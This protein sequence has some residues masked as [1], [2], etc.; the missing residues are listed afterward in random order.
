MPTYECSNC[1]TKYMTK[2]DGNFNCCNLKCNNA[3]LYKVLIPLASQRSQPYQKRTSYAI[4]NSKLQLK[5]TTQKTQHRR[6]RTYDGKTDTL[7]PS[8]QIDYREKHDDDEYENSDDE[9]AT[10]AV[11]ALVDNEELDREA[12]DSEFVPTADRW[13]FDQRLTIGDMKERTQYPN[14]LSQIKKSRLSP[15]T[16]QIE[17]ERAKDCAQIIGQALGVS[18]V[19]AWAIS[20]Q[21]GAPIGRRWSLGE[22]DTAEWCH[23]VGVALGGKTTDDNLVAASY[24]ANT[25]MGVIEK[26][27]QGRTDLEVEIRV[28]GQQSALFGSK[29]S[30]NYDHIAEKI[31]YAISKVG[32]GSAL[33]A[34]TIDALI[35]GFSKADADK[36]AHAVKNALPSFK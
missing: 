17:G 9:R 19:S 34:F 26:A 22:K 11:L 36:V 20:N 3:P 12:Q 35:S 1:S 30:K 21:V 16:A 10:K 13:N 8:K 4:A 14:G 29:N 27:V 15:I 33:I 25:Y 5:L 23:L 2:T 18:R 31:E 24:C 32:S 6:L 28:E 7:D